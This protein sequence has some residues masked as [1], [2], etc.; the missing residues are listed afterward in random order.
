[1]VSTAVYPA[2]GAAVPAATSKSIVQ[3]ILRGQLGFRG[4]VITDA[5]DTPAVARY[6]GTGIATV[7]A[8]QAGADAVIAAGVTPTDADAASTS[9]YNAELAAAKA[10]TLSQANLTASY[11][12]ILALKQSLPH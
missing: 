3:G 10:G 5:L 1:M 11:Q 7:R 9:A 12:R 6:Y 8:L 4:V 2:L